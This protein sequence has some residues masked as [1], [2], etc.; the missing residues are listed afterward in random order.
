MPFAESRSKQPILD[1]RQDPVA[2]K[3]VERHSTAQGLRFAQ[4]PRTKHRIGA[5]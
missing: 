1:G 3:L 5:T 4:H 2:H